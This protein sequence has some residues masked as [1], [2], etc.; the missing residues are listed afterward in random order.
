[1]NELVTAPREAVSTRSSYVDW[2]AIL[3]GAAAAAALSFLL[4]TFGAAL[5]LSSTSPWSGLSARGMMI[6]AAIWIVLAQVGSFAAGGYIAGR[7]RMRIAGTPQNEVEFR[8]GAH[9]FLVWT[10]G[11]LIG[12]V[13]LASAA[14]TATRAGSQVAGSIGSAA[15][16]TLN[17]ALPSNPLEHTIDVLLRPTTT[18]S[19]RNTP[20]EDRPADVRAAISRTLVASARSGELTPA[21]KTYLGQVIA[22]RTGSDQAAAEARVDAAVA[23]VRRTAADLEIQAKEAADKARRSALITGFLTAASLLI[24]CAVAAIAAGVGG[25]HRDEGTP[26]RIFKSDRFW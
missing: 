9:G 16:A 22:A 14:A 12:A 19:T 17:E 2:S 23:Q 5:G 7:L 8:D 21:D 6:W 25:R 3:A 24:S 4:M 13:A 15:V 1:M 26:L 10:M 20:A 11:V 18:G